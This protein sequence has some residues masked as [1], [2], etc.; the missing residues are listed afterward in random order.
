MYGTWEQLQEEKKTIRP[1]KIEIN[2]SDADITRIY[3]KA[4]KH[5]ITV[6]ELIE[7]FIGDLVDGTHNNGSDERMYANEWFERCWFGGFSE[8]TFLGYLLE[9]EQNI[10]HVIDVW[11]DIE[12]NGEDLDEDDEEYL[13]YCKKL[14]DE[15]WEEY[16]KYLEEKEFGSKECGVLDEEMKKVLDYWER[17]QRSL[18]DGQ[19]SNYVSNQGE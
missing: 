10:K 1:R 2:L 9:S 3:E 5:G 6:E 17:Y 13:D 12:Y 7:N 16:R 11:Q 8:N 18:N 4:G 19:K 14:I 15:Y